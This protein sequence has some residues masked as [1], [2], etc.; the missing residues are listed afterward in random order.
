[1]K[2]DDPKILFDYA[3]FATKALDIQSDDALALNGIRCIVRIIQITSRGAFSPLL[4]LMSSIA[5]FGS[6]RMLE[7]PVF[8][9]IRRFPR[10][11]TAAV[12]PQVASMMSHPSARVRQ[13][14]ISILLDLG[15][16]EF[17]QLFHLLT[18]TVQSRDPA[19]SRTAREVYEKLTANERALADELQAFVQGMR[20]ASTSMLEYWK[21]GIDDARRASHSGNESEMVAILTDLLLVLDHPTCDLDRGRSGRPLRTGKRSSEEIS[22]DSATATGRAC[23]RCGAACGAFLN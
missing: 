3:L 6:D 13:F 1:L 12:I 21:A 19:M 23:F 4:L 15:K 2:P 8:D 10:G 5:R 17:Q 11:A 22:A 7:D 20:K 14:A 9:E 16:K 18:I